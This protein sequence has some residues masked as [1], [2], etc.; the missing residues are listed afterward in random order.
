M[1]ASRA[2]TA[3]APSASWRRALRLRAD[4][5][6]CF[7]Q[8]RRR[9]ASTP[10]RVR[11][12]DR[13]GQNSC[14]RRPSGV[15]APTPRSARSCAAARPPVPLPP[16]RPDARRHRPP[17]PCAGD[18][19]GAGRT[20]RALMVSARFGTRAAGITG[21]L[22][23]AH[24]SR[25]ARRERRLPHAARGARA[26]RRSSC[27]RPA[28]MWCMSASGSR[29]RPRRCSCA[30]RR[31]ARCSSSRP[32]ALRLEGRVGDSRI[33]PAQIIV[34]RLPRQPVRR[35][36]TSAP[37]A[38]G[39][40]DR[41]R[42]AAAGGHLSRRFELR[43]Q[44][45]D[46]A[47][48]HPRAGRQADRRGGQSSRRGHHAQ[49]GQRT[50]AARRS[51]IPQ[52]SVLTPGGDVVKEAIG[53]FPKVILAEGEYSVVARNEGKTS[54]TANSKWNPASTGRLKYWPASAGTV[55]AVR[56]QTCYRSIS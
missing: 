5:V 41:R 18:P 51:P 16:P 11:P 33:P 19:D 23:L 43:R 24:L 42:G 6:A 45:R 13:A 34:R 1:T 56:Q 54:T 46:G 26:P 4:G 47:L 3:W 44:Q 40:R 14:R 48:R 25:Q 36:A 27:C 9:P 37:L 7:A 30:P 29:P 12:A 50:A 55:S 53:A 39:C 32:A 49:A 20:G 15:L 35:R 28:A 10:F 38:H 52:W 17:Q 8:R 22:H 31:C 2:A 21:G